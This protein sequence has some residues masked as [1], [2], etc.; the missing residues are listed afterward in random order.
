M[1]GW[2]KWKEGTV[3]EN[4]IAGMERGRK[5]EGG[6]KVKRG[7]GEKGAKYEGGKGGTRK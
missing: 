2:R 3:H 6:D 5:R 7:M 1:E 4:R